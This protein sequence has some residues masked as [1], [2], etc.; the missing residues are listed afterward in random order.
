MIRKTILTLIAPLFVFASVALAAPEMG[1]TDTEG[2]FDRIQRETMCLCGCNST[3][4]SCPHINCDFAVPRRNEI[5]QMINE[6]KTHDQI[7]AAMVERFS[8]KVLSA[9][10]K[11]GFNLLGY[12]MPFLALVAVGSVV[13]VTVKKWAGRSAVRKDAEEVVAPESKPLSVEDDDLA[14]LLKKELSEFDE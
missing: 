13:G 12:F 11:E 1:G 2:L 6:G 3:L 8:E 10:K 5:R 14:D 7:I 4:K 9:P